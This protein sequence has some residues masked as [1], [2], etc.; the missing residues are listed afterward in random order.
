MCRL[1]A[2]HNT[3][4]L[5]LLGLPPDMVHGVSLHRA[6]TSIF[7]NFLLKSHFK[8]FIIISQ[9]LQIVKWFWIKY[10]ESNWE[11]KN[12]NRKND[13]DLLAPPV[14]LEPTTTRLTAECSTDWAMEEYLCWH[15]FIFPGRRQPS[16]FNADELNFRVLNGNGCD[17][18]AIST[19]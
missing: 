5:M 4:R 2:A 19:S 15:C 12:P 10:K 13:S 11:N 1:A 3:H 17:L 16:I 7:R 14:G 9:V 6:R 8:S 18:T